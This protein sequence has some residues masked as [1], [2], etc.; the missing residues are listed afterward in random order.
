MKHA[1]V[2]KQYLR[3]RRGE[4]FVAEAF[5]FVTISRE[6]GAGG[7]TLAAEIVRKLE[8]LR[9]GAF[10]EDWE[11]FDD[12][13]CALI[14]EDEKLGV[15]F[16]QLLTEEYRSEVNEVVTELI[17]QRAKRYEVFKRVFGIVR[18]LGTLGKCVVVGRAGMCVTADMPL[19]VHIRLVAPEPVR[20]KRMMKLLRLGA[21]EAARKMKAQDEDRQRLV[22]DFFG[23]NVDDP[24]LYDAVFNTDRLAIPEIADAVARL[25]LQR[26]DRYERSTK[27]RP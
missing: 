20:L 1:A 13:L 10:A 17:A 3:E 2:I 23:K 9:P 15:S 16:D 4:E 8:A 27:T 22:R 24:L 12:Q 26:M 7:R 11:V 19:G 18:M 14:A 5:P 25:V 6:A 21:A